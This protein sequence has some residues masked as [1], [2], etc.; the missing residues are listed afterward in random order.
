MKSLIEIHN[1]YVIKTENPEF[2]EIEKYKI[3]NKNNFP[4]VK[5]IDVIREG[6]CKKLKLQKA[7]KHELKTTNYDDY[8]KVIDWLAEINLILIEEYA[9]LN[10]DYI[11]N[12]YNEF[13]KLH[14]IACNEDDL[15]N[16]KGIKDL[17]KPIDIFEKFIKIIETDKMVISHGDPADSNI[18]MIE[19]KIVGFDLGLSSKNHPIVDFAL[20]TGAQ[21]TEYPRN[22]DINA[23]L[24]KYLNKIHYSCKN[25][26]QKYAVIGCIYGCYMEKEPVLSI[27]N[28]GSKSKYYE[29]CNV[30]LNR[31]K[32]YSKGV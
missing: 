19:G 12:Y 14:E 8:A 1:E 16:I 26:E 3:L 11:K 27:L 23:E 21:A 28:D 13:S 20:R 29:W 32:K 17:P 4:I 7:E 9:N 2:P 18:G 30:T 25:I 22:L 24:R 6:E 15:F 31:Y 5:L 10:V